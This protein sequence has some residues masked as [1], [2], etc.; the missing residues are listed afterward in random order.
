MG[1]EDVEKRRK[2]ERV[3][4]NSF[5]FSQQVSNILSAYSGQMIF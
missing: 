2:G 5:L 3:L 4:G 1:T